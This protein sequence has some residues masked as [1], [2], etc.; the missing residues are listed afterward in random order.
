[1]DRSASATVFSR[2]GLLLLM[3]AVLVSLAVVAPL[4]VLAWH[5]LLSHSYTDIYVVVPARFLAAMVGG[6]LAVLGSS[7]LV[8][9]RARTIPGQP[10]GRA[11]GTA[12]ALVAGSWLVFGIAWAALS[13]W[14][15]P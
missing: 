15:A 9:R 7:I 1:M 2:L 8:R 10:G 3:G 13:A 12:I 6:S 4:G 14:F 11:A 5:Q